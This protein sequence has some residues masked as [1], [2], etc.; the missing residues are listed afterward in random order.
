[1]GQPNEAVSNF[2]A[3]NQLYH[4]DLM[5]GERRQFSFG[6]NMIGGEFIFVPRDGSA[7]EGDGWLMGLVI[8]AAADTTQL[9]FFDALNIENGPTG[10]IHI[11]HRIPPGFHGNWIPD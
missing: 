6:A 10:A 4:H 2:G 1:M 9:Q 5:T 8:D 7:E 3:E 11:P